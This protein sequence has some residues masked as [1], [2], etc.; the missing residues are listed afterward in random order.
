MSGTLRMF[1]ISYPQ[2]I[3]YSSVIG[4]SFIAAFARV[5]QVHPGAGGKGEHLGRG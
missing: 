2:A 1:R 4:F 3:V 5:A